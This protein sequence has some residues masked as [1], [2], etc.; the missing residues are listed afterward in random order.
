M[1]PVVV[2]VLLF[3]FEQP[4]NATTSSP[5]NITTAQRD[6]KRI[7]LPLKISF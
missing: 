5:A 7:L 1:K 3:E 4:V 2:V 6:F